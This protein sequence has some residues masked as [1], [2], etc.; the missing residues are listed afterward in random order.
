[1]KPVRTLVLLAS[2]GEA[3]LL[4]N[5]G[6]GKGLHQIGHLD[7]DAVSGD[8]IA[9]ADGPG[10]SQAAPGAAHHGMEPSSSV[11]RQNRERFAADLVG[12]VEKT[13]TKGGYDRLMIAA[14]PKM[15]GA[16][17]DKLPKALAGKLAV[18]LAKDLIHTPVADLPKHFSDVAAF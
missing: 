11:S 10:R 7:R 4:E 9:Y 1:M 14:P 2:E 18:D 5:D 17:R 13:W 12:E 6:V 16:L 8:A 3:R 15:L